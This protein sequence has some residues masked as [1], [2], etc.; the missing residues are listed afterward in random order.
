MLLVWFDFFIFFDFVNLL[1]KII[2]LFFLLFVCVVDDSEIGDS[3]S[4]KEG[5]FDNFFKFFFVGF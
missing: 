3:F 1:L 4:D 2:L 5:G